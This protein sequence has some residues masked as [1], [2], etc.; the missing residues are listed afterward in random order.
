MVVIGKNLEQL[1]RQFKICESFLVDEF[2]LKIQLGESYYDIEKTKEGQKIIYGSSQ[3]VSVMYTSIKTIEQNL[4]LEPNQ[5]V[6]ACSK[7]KFDIPLDYFGIVQT[8]GTL[9]RLFVQATC[10]DGQVEP[11][12]NGF[13]TLEIMN[14]SP[15]VIELPA[16]C[17]VAQLYL[18]KCS[19]PAEKGYS[20]RYFQQSKLGP[21]LPSF[22]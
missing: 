20:G 16:G 2:S 7:Q 13:I 14:L 15:W 6:I 1:A 9:A 19:S 12:F 11:G 3:D 22:K 18:F 5:R 8:K 4:K 10:N 17:E 21:T